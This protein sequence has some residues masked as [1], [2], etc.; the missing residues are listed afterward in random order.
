MIRPF[1]ADL[2]VHSLLSPC[3]EV[4]MTPR[5]IVWHAAQHGID[6]IAITDH[7]AADNVMAALEAAKGTGVTVIPG[8]EVE[9]KEEIHLIVL[10][11]KIRQLKVWQQYV[12]AHRS[13][14]FN[15][16]TRFGAQF[17][18]DAEDNLVSV[19][20][21]LLLGPLTAGVKEITGSVRELGGIC[22]ASH[23]DRPAYSIISQLGFIP[24]DI[25]LAAVEVSRRIKPAEAA[26]RLP[27]ISGRTVI[28]CSDAHTIQDFLTGP[29][30]HFHIEEPT[31]NEVIM[32]LKGL[33]GRKAVV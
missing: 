3:A 16:E 25:E 12:D 28:T 33:N 24:D 17:I 18:V 23:I 19:K 27:A 32:A 26:A 2:H 29:N 6:I 21:E 1:T 11:E 22:I 13:G 9:T 7:N 8:M 30:T 5:N 31:L 20:P 4:E 15:D 10:F 14:A